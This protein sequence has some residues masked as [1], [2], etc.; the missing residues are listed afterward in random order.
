MGKKTE[1]NQAVWKCTELNKHKINGGGFYLL[2][3]L[4]I[5]NISGILTPIRIC[6]LPNEVK[7]IR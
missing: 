2:D 7:T 5:L 6:E 4:P 3:Y 1:N